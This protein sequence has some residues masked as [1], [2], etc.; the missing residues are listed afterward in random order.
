MPTRA[1]IEAAVDSAL[2]DARTRIMTEL[3]SSPTFDVGEAPS[4]PFPAPSSAPANLRSQAEF[5]MGG[6]MVVSAQSGACSICYE[7]KNSDVVKI[8]AC[9]HVYHLTCVLVW[10]QSNSARRGSCPICRQKL[11]EPSPLPVAV[12]AGFNAQPSVD[13]LPARRGAYGHAPPRAIQNDEESHVFWER[14]HE[15]EP[16]DIAA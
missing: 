3:A 2:R 15:F 9:G 5:F 4:T 6:V 10:F 8:L 16:V 12:P 7:D 1:E 14:H 13:A 11:F